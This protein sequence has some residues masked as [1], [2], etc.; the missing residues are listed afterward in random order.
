MKFAFMAAEKANFPVRFMCRQLGV[1]ASGFYASQVR[2][3]C[4]RASRDRELMEPIRKAHQEGRQHYGSPRVHR[5]LVL[6]GIRVG[7]HRVARLMRAGGIR[8][9]RK[10]RF[11]K[12]TDSNHAHPIAPNVLERNFHVS[13]PNK[14]W[15]TD[16]TYIPTGEGWLY[17]AVVLD[18]YS[19]RVVGWGMD[20]N[21]ERGLVV[22]M[23]N[24]ALQRRKPAAHL[25]HHSDRGSQY[26]SKEYRDI[27]TARGITCSMS[28]TGDCWDNAV[29]ESFFATLKKEFVHDERFKTRDEAK[30][31]LFEWIEVFYNRKRLHSTLGYKSPARYEAD[32]QPLSKAA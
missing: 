22:R 21:M 27:L 14:A 13:E 31:K 29:A 25:T 18:L 1:S 19:R 3:E 17:L 28:R 10:R 24:M 5:A 8:G 32:Q 30:A 2:P 9:L 11:V 23:L 16:I 12:T 7:R 26:A 6:E 15:V 4:P 20:D